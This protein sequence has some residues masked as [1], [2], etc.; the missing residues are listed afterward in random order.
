MC[1]ARDSQLP[2]EQQE[3]IVQQAVSQFGPLPHTD[4]EQEVNHAI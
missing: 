1:S 4:T 2:E 3:G